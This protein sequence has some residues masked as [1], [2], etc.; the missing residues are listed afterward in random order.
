M[1]ATGSGSSGDLT[2]E[3]L[4]ALSKTDPILS[5]DAFPQVPFTELKGALDRL[6]SR[7]MITY[8]TIE[9]D[10]A[11]L[12]P[13]G[14]EIVAKGSH[15]ARVF[16]AV[17]QA[18]EGLAISD[19]E[20]VIGDKNVVKVGQGKA[21][22]EKWISKTKDNKLVA[23]VRSGAFGDRG[24]GVTDLSVERIYHRYHTR[25]APDHSAGGYSPGCKGAHRPE[26]AQTCEDAESYQ[27][28]NTQRSEV[29]A[30]DSKG[31]DRPHG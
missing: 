16:E 28:Q 8:E 15:E 7:S 13:E 14:Q 24:F 25:T 31:G 27:L 10:K 5:A 20:K 26:E 12:E 30:R 23:S 9:K 29:R 17:R 4:Q 21:F 22:K 2:L 1:A 6:G 3:V 11:I 18:L 19:L